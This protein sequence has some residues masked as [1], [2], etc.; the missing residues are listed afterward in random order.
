MS[1]PNIYSNGDENDSK[2]NEIEAP[3]L[4]IKRKNLA[5]ALACHTQNLINNYFFYQKFLALFKIPSPES[6]TDLLMIFFMSGTTGTFVTSVLPA[7]LEDNHDENPKVSN[8]IEISRKVIGFDLRHHRGTIEDDPYTVYFFLNKTVTQTNLDIDDQTFTA[9]TRK[10]KK[11]EQE[12]PI[13]R[14]ISTSD[15]LQAL[16]DQPPQ[17]NLLHYYPIPK[18]DI[19]NLSN[20]NLVDVQAIDRGSFKRIFFEWLPAVNSFVGALLAGNHLGE[21]IFGDSRHY[22]L[23]ELWPLEICIALLAGTKAFTNFKRKYK[24]ARTSWESL[25]YYFKYG[26]E[27]FHVSSSCFHA[28]SCCESRQSFKSFMWKLLC[29]LWIVLLPN[30]AASM[31][32]TA[33]TFFFIHNG[34]IEQIVSTACELTTACNYHFDSTAAQ[35]NIPSWQYNYFAYPL[36]L[37]SLGTVLFT[38][39]PTSLSQYEQIVSEQTASQTHLNSEQI[40]PQVLHKT[41]WKYARLGNWI[42]AASQ[43]LIISLGS[44]SAIAY[45]FDTDITDPGAYVPGS[46]LGFWASYS[47]LHFQKVF[48]KKKFDDTC[49]KLILFRDWLKKKCGCCQPNETERPLLLAS[50]CHSI[51]SA[52]E[53]GSSNSSYSS[54]ESSDT[55]GEVVEEPQQRSWCCIM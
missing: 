11:L 12:G 30:A 8:L 45:F 54:M 25:L 50:D 4:P 47:Y 46:I 2:R 31:T 48:G 20:F 5:A 22:K 34:S 9:I 28:S 40:V 33:A 15:E 42:D 52:T 36:M 38:Q 44:A 51:Q 23:W 55:N 1:R 24:K 7:A 26:K 6:V 37:I 13:I 18:H 29:K 32:F 14:I 43:I 16:P 53:N 17:S 35:P 21:R 49:E 27:R 3:P 10:I 19:N 41:A 39:I